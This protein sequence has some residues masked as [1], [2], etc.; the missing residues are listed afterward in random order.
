M[1]SVTYNGPNVTQERIFITNWDS[2][3]TNSMV[4]NVRFQWG[5]DLEITGANF[6]PPA[7]ASEQPGGECA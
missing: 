1:R 2:T 4:N 5:R 7:S 6:G 3:I